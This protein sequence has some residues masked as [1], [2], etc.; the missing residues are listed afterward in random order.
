MQLTLVR[1]PE[2]LSVQ[3][4]GKLKYFDSPHSC[5]ELP[6]S[7]QW[8]IS[9]FLPNPENSMDR[10]LET[11]EVRALDSGFTLGYLPFPQTQ[12][13][14]MLCYCE[15]A[16]VRE[17]YPLLGTTVLVYPKLRTSCSHSP[18]LLKGRQWQG[19]GWTQRSCR[20]PNNLTFRECY[21]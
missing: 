8:E 16:S 4:K 20:V 19:A 6:R 21:S 10:N 11:L 2:E 15:D 3:G 17:L 12:A 7:L 1:S 9:S 5:C 13:S 14:T 18:V